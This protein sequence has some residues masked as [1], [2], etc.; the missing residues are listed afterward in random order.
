M[1]LWFPGVSAQTLF[2]IIIIIN[3]IPSGIPGHGCAFKTIGVAALGYY[4][5]GTEEHKGKKNE[6]RETGEGRRGGKKPNRDQDG[7]ANNARHQRLPTFCKYAV[8]CLLL[9][10][11]F[12]QNSTALTSYSRQELLDVGLYNSNCFITDL[13]LIPEISKTPESA[14]SSWPW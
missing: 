7:G 13:Q 14:H 12:T 9:T 5:C 8:F 4:V 2:I 10:G 3:H 1:L 6:R 11:L